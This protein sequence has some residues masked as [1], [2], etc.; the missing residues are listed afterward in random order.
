MA[1]TVGADT[2][3]S[4]APALDDF[5]VA[6]FLSLSDDE[7]LASPSFESFP[8]GVTLETSTT[9]GV[10]VARSVT[11]D[12]WLADTFDGPLR[13][14]PGTPAP[15]PGDVLAGFLLDGAAARSRLAQSGS[16]RYVGPKHL[17][18]PAELDF[19]VATSDQL[20]VSGVGAASGLSYSQAQ[21][22]LSAELALHP[23]RSGAAHRECS[24]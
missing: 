9:F 11:Y 15:L 6:Q 21:A 5:A 23:E 12:T 18:A 22:A 10:P 7:K 1:V 24:V 20:T 19:V 2:K 13:E 16:A 4:T 17:V 14:D 8:S 3:P